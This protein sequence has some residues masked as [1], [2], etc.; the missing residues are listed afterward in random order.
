MNGR[1]V[2]LVEDDFALNLSLSECLQEAGL[3]VESV[4]C[5]QAALEIIDRGWHIAAL[6]S[7][8]ELGPGADGFAIARR[9]RIA[10]PGLP[11]LFISGASALRHAVEGVEDSVFIPKP[12]EPRHVANILRGMI[13]KEAA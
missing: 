4:Y 1:G 3:R 2:L 9:A 7:D 11:V 12:V 5:A 10:H 13:L 6:V 8:V